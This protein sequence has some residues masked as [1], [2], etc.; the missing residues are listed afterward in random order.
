MVFTTAVL[1]W[2]AG[3]YLHPAWLRWLVFGW[4]LVLVNL[5]TVGA[6]LSGPLPTDF[7]FVLIS[8]QI[9]LLMIWSLL[10]DVGWQWRLPGLA[11]FG[12]V[13]ILFAG[14]FIS[15]W[16]TRSWGILMILTTI[17][18]AVVCCG[19]RLRGFTLRQ[20]NPANIRA[21]QR[22]SVHQFGTKHMLVWAA[23]MAPLFIV[24]RGLEFL[25][26]SDLNASTAFQSIWLS[27]AIATLNLLAIWAVHGSG[28]WPIRIAAL[29]LLPYALSLGVERYANSL[30]PGLGRSWTALTY[31]LREMRGQWAFWLS[32]NAVLLAA[33][34]LFVRANGY[35]LL[36]SARTDRMELGQ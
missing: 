5:I 23:A 31:M 13:L 10:A 28:A 9:S 1:S 35:R 20:L 34:L 19:L 33:L 11:A 8:S 16:G 7:A 15:N 3:R 18:V 12:A 2:C 30:Y 4:C 17:I 32:L 26:F 27:L 14:S 29:I 36:R 25:I 21:T 6:C 24:A 22:S